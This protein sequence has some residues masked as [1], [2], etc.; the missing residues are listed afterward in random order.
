[1]PAPLPLA[2]PTTAESPP[3]TSSA[4]REGILLTK[5]S[6]PVK[7]LQRART[8][9]EAIEQHKTGAVNQ[10]REFSREADDWSSCKNTISR[11]KRLYSVLEVDFKDDEDRFFDFFS[12]DPKKVMLLKQKHPNLPNKMHVACNMLTDKLVP[13]CNTAI[14][15]EQKKDEYHVDG[16][17]SQQVWEEHWGDKNRWEIFKE[18]DTTLAK[19]LGE[20]L[21]DEEQ[22]A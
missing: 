21:A 1:M 22:G 9:R 3:H 15:A 10:Q 11:R 13:A 5:I 4:S 16:E 18:L 8:L 17:F 7:S 6:K 12:L 14:E 20:I 2:A 19:A